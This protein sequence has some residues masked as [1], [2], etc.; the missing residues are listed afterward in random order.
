ML[1]NDEVKY[2]KNIQVHASSLAN[3]I[4]MH[5]E[6]S[7]IENILVGGKHYKELT[8]NDIQ[9]VYALIEC[10]EPPPDAAGGVFVRSV[11][12]AHGYN[13]MLYREGEFCIVSNS[14]GNQVVLEIC[15]IFSLKISEVYH[16]YFIK[17][18]VYDRSDKEPTHPYS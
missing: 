8:V 5:K 12:M 7:E 15:E 3:A 11:Y 9:D 6:Y 13:G 10:E 16:N 2:F 14:R 1:I 18:N 4:K 17:G